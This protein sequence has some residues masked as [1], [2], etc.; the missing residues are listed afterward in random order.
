MHLMGDDKDY[1]NMATYDFLGL[2]IKEKIHEKAVE[3]LRKYGVGAC[4]PPGFYGTIDVHLELEKQLAKFLGQEEAIIYAQAFSTISGVIP[5]FSKRHD[6]L[7]VDDGVC[8]AVQKGVQISRS[9][10][11]YFKH[12]DMQDLERVLKE[13]KYEDKKFRRP[14]SRR[15][16]VIEGLYQNF[17]DIAPLPEILKL[18]EKFKY[19]LIVEE[20]MSFGVLGRRGAGICD[21]FGVDPSKVEIISAS[22]AHS[23][24]SAGGFCAGSKEIVDHQVCY[25]ATVLHYLTHDSYS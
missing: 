22:M 19:R 21:H 4:G 9:V 2:S 17:G 3:A 20:S 7:V 5:A 24:S 12:N 15:F 13:I 23:L 25:Y 14:L 6:I 10:V 8:F 16:I 1:L 11:K 18:K